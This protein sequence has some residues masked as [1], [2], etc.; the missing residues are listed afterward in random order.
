M[1]ANLPGHQGPTDI[2]TADMYQEAFD[3]EPN[4]GPLV[5]GYNRSRVHG[6]S[7]LDKLLR[8][9]NA[10]PD[11]YIEGTECSPLWTELEGAQFKKGSGFRELSEDLDERCPDHGI[12]AAI[13]GLHTHL[14]TP[15]VEKSHHLTPQQVYEAVRLKQ[16]KLD[17]ASFEKFKKRQNRQSMRI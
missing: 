15:E 6:L 17:Q 11:W 9:E 8:R 16:D 7:T 12:T 4:I 1:W 10:Y 2:S 3:G 5:R 14:M 13:Y